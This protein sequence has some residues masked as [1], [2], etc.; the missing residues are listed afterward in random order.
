MVMDKKDKAQT[1]P[2][3]YRLHLTVIFH[4]AAMTRMV[5]TQPIL[6]AMSRADTL[7][8]ILD[9]TLWMNTHVALDQQRQ[10]VEAYATFKRKI[11]EIIEEHGLIEQFQALVKQQ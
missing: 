3:T 5:D 7:G 1:D 2:E 4:Q 10:V 8:P 6:D 9:P 11:A